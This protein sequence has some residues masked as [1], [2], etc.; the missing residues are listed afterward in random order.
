MRKRDLATANVLFSQRL[1]QPL[2]QRS[3]RP[4]EMHFYNP[5]RRVLR[6]MSRDLWT[7]RAVGA[8]FT[9]ERCNISRSELL[10][11]TGGLGINTRGPSCGLA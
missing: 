8:E 10:A 2:D 9:S 1:R 7:Y 5:S 4:I 3:L 6:C 11:G